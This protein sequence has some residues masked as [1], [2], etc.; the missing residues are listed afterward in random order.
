VTPRRAC[1]R[2][3]GFQFALVAPSIFV[4]L[5][6]GVFPLV[7]LILVSFQNITMTDADT[8]FQG[9]LN[10]QRLFSDRR[11][12]EALLHTGIFIVIALP[13]ELM[14]GLA[15][16]QLFPAARSSSRCWCCRCWCRPSWPAPPGR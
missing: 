1:P 5:L 2:E 6:I 15:M 4:L 13:I 16:A 11:L 10:Y 9:L 14:L 7:Y 8:S 12:W 3:R